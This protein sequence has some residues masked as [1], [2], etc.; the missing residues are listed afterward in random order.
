MIP[1][2]KIHLTNRLKETYSRSGHGLLEKAPNE[3][4]VEDFLRLLKTPE[5]PER[6]VCHYTTLSALES[7]VSSR[8]FWLSHGSKLNDKYEYNTSNRWTKTYVASFSNSTIDNVAMWVIYT[9]MKKDITDE[10]APVRLDFPKKAVC[11]WFQSLEKHAHAV[12]IDA[13][14]KSCGEV[15]VKRWSLHEVGYGE[16]VSLDEAREDMSCKDMYR[17]KVFV[18]GES[19]HQ[20]MEELTGYWKQSGWAYEKE[21]RLLAQLH[22]SCMK[23]IRG[24]K[25]MFPAR[26]AVPCEELLGEMSV[27]IGPCPSRECQNLAWD[28]VYNLFGERPD[29]RSRL[30]K[31]DLILNLKADKSS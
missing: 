24:G 31:S 5:N 16:N 29:M 14:G 28:H 25:K 15:Q 8:T 19:R 11:K 6:S 23:V 18:V 17:D 20:A 12:A 26:I 9:L 10:N 1:V 30:H 2:L 3:L 4:P 21:T 22:S 27:T 13:R 7:I